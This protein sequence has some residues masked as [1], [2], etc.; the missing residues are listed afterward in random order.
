MVT[1][2]EYFLDKIESEKVFVHL[3]MLFMALF[4]MILIVICFIF[5][6]IREDYIFNIITMIIGSFLGAGLLKYARGGE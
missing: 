2:L 5:G 1:K 6:R 4:L 3:L